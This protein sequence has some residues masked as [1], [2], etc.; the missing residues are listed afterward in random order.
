[1]KKN[2]LMDTRLVVLASLYRL[3]NPSLPRGST[4]GAIQLV[5]ITIVKDAIE[6]GEELMDEQ[7]VFQVSSEKQ[8]QALSA[9][10]LEID[11][12]NLNDVLNGTKK[13]PD[14]SRCEVDGCGKGV[15]SR[16]KCISHGGGKRCEVDGCEN[17]AE[18]KG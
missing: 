5:I 9:S 8:T 11:R 16:G 3:M 7:K 15:L 4:T 6:N 14:E 10:P 1:M 13:I 17:G 18:R 2:S 12:D